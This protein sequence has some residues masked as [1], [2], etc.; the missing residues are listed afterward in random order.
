MYTVIQANECGYLMKN[1]IF[2]RLLL[3]GR[4]HYFK[5]FGYEI[6]I[7]P[8]TGY[9]ET[10]SIPLEILLENKDFAER[11]VRVQI[12]DSC[13]ALHFV[14]GAYKAVL[15]DQ[16]AICWNV[17]EKNEFQLVDITD[18]ETGNNIPPMYRDLLP[19]RMYK[20]IEIK[21]GETG[22][23]Y[24]DN[25]YIR[26]LERGTYYYWNYTA[27][28]TCKILSQKLQQLEINGQEILTADKVGIRLNIICSYKITDPLALVQKID[29]LKEQLYVYIQLVMREYIGRYKLDELLA[30]KEEISRFLYERLVKNQ[31]EYCVS[32]FQ[33]GIKD[34]ILPGEIRDIM[35]TVLLAEKKAQANVITRREEV[36]STRSL[37]NTAKLMEENKTLFQLKELEYLEKI[38]DKIGSISVA[39]GGGILEQLKELFTAPQP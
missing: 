34:I 32:F 33:A 30:Q 12:P 21:D 26:Q 17:Y 16:E 19:A 25:Q 11:T 22:L 10:C 29:N 3:P 7:V 14:N 28:V 18:P 2:L 15:I 38:C 24:F 1:G 5:Q 13:I 37:L 9:V 4:H 23:L 31:E 20:K 36:A 6:K 39:G 8:M 27:N 35:N